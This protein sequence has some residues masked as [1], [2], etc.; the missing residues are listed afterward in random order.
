MTSLR[1]LLLT[2]A[3]V[4]VYGACFRLWFSFP[5]SPL[6]SQENLGK[7]MFWGKI[8]GETNDYLIAYALIPAFGFPQKKF[9]YCTTG[10]YSLV[11]MPV[12]SEEWKS[13]SAAITSPFKGEPSH[14]LEPGEDEPADDAVDPEGGGPPPKEKFREGCRCHS[15]PIAR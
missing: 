10:D 2:H 8:T 6:P 15:R 5:S 1:T 9:Y 3:T 11:Q 4:S 12:V 14:L 13:L 7:L